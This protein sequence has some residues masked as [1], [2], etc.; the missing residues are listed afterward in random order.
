M[1]KGVSDEIPYKPYNQGQAYL[2][3]PG[4]DDLIPADNLVRLVSE[5]I[6]QMVIERL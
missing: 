2:I 1:S 5:V 6:E 4:V 3:P